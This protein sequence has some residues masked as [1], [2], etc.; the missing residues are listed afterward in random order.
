[1]PWLFAQGE[2]EGE[3]VDVAVAVVASRDQLPRECRTRV[4]R[5]VSF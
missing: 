5:S 1:M 4:E 2:D 3:V